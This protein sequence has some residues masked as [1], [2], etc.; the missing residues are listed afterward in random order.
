MSTTAKAKAREHR[1]GVL[2][3]MSVLLLGAAL[4]ALGA[5]N[6]MEGAGQDVEAAG[7]AMSDTAEDV[8]N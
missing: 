3:L 8:Q 4:L 7:D 6:T 2:L 5:C 1:S